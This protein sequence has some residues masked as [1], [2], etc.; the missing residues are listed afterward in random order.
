M[1]SV[2]TKTSDPWFSVRQSSSQI[3]PEGLRKSTAHPLSSMWCRL[4]D[5]G[6]VCTSSGAQVACLTERRL[7][8][9]NNFNFSLL[10]D[11]STEY[12]REGG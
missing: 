2:E 5:T 9:D 3:L 6:T 7:F 1:R 8:T 12:S 4:T 10:S 11:L